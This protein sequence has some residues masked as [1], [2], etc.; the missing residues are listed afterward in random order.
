MTILLT[1]LIILLPTATFAADVTLAWDA[2]PDPV[3][4]YILYRSPDPIV[5]DITPEARFTG[6][7]LQFVWSDVPDGLSY[8]RL[9]A[10]N[11]YGK[12]PFS[13]E[14]AYQSVTTTTTAP[15]QCELCHLTPPAN[16][17]VLE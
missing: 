6:N 15:V 16:L 4:G 12:S 5:D 13:N 17:R 3:D 10:Y 14:V 2:S 8:F 9:K 1:L 7:V 11:A